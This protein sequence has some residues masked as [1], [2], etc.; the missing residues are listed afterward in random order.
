[1]KKALTDNH[2]TIKR[3][4]LLILMPSLL[5]VFLLNIHDQTTDYPKS[6]TQKEYVN[7]VIKQDVNLIFYKRDCPYCK[8]GKR[9]IISEAN[10]SKRTTY[11]VDVTTAE[12]KA[13]V[14]KYN[15]DYAPSIVTIRKGKPNVYLYAG[16]KS[17]KKIVYK[18]VIKT[19][20]SNER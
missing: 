15:V 2:I 10:K 5:S 17:G 13:L 4:W 9:V 12:G 16:E 11:F 14:K 19:V 18:N 1:M 6:L 20:F 3:F 7:T 8:A